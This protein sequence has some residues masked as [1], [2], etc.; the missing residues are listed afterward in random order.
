M[1]AELYGL[2]ATGSTGTQSKRSQ[3]AALGGQ[4]KVIVVIVMGSTGK[5]MSTRAKRFLWWHDSYGPLVST[6]QSRGLQA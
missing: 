6:D 3:A 2:N 5:A 4:I 1:P